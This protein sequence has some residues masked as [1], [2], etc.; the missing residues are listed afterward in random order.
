MERG[1]PHKELLTK[2]IEKHPTLEQSQ[3]DK[4]FYNAVARLA[5]GG[6]ITKFGGLLYSTRV[7]N[8]LREKGEKLPD[9]TLEVRRRAGGSAQ[10]VIEILEKHPGGLSGPDLK[11]VVAEIPEAPKSVREH[12]QYIYNILAT[13]MGS[14]VV[15]KKDGIYRL[16]KTKG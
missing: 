6:E 2:I 15:T 10:I 1:I 14:G 8:L 7:V 3:G 9:M 5:K 16:K 12:G 4:G 11:K 13:L